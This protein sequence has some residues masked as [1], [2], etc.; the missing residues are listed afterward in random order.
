MSA[1]S[2]QS[3]FYAYDGDQQITLPQTIGGIR[4]SL[5]ADLVPEFDQMVTST[6]AEELF[7]ELAVWALRTRPGLVERERETCGRL[8]QGDF[9]GFTPAEDVPELA[10]LDEEGNAA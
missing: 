2:G 8:E 3:P 4:Q 9:T 10:F 5:A 6:P 1:T 7:A